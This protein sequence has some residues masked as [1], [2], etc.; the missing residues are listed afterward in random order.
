M[1]CSDMRWARRLRNVE[2]VGEWELAMSACHSTPF[3]V[4]MS[5]QQALKPLFL[6]FFFGPHIGEVLGPL[7]THGSLVH[8]ITGV[9]G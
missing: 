9:H 8:N 6:F 4:A 5:S 1:E 3:E 7:P 2:D